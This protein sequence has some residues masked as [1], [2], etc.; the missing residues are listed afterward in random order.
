LCPRSRFRPWS[1]KG[2]RQVAGLDPRLVVGIMKRPEPVFVS[3]P[4]HFIHL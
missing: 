1:L 2:R 4:R 3:E